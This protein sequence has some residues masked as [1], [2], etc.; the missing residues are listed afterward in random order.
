MMFNSKK[1]PLITRETEGKT[2]LFVEI[3]LHQKQLESTIFQDC[4]FSWGLFF[5]GGGSFS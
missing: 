5:W 1:R 3:T 2:Y 4:A